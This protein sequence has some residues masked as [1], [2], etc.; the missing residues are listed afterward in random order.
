MV[1]TSPCAAPED[2]LCVAL[3]AGRLLAGLVLL[4]S[5]L[6]QSVGAEASSSGTPEPAADSVGA[7]PS[8]AAHFS[9][10]SEI[11]AENVAGLSLSFSFRTG[12]PRGHAAA[13]RV[14]GDTLLV[15]TP[16][17]HR[18]YALDLSKPDRPVRWTYAP[19]ADP[20][21][22]GLACCD[23]LNRGPVVADGRVYFNTLDG[24]TI[25]LDSGSGRVVWDVASASLAAGETLT[26][27]PLVAGGRVYIGN[28]GDDFGARGWIAA[29]EAETGREIWRRYSTGPDAEV[30]IGPAFKPFYPG[31][32]GPDL[33]V[34]TWPP[35][36]WEH[37]GGSVSGPLLHDPDLDLVIHG[38]GHPAPWNP[39]QRPGDNKWT[40]G[41]F[42]R[43]AASGAARWFDQLNPHDL[44]ALGA[45]AAS[46]P[47][48]RD[49]RGAR[50]R[51][52]IHAGAN[53]HVYVLDRL[54]GEILS[55]EPFTAVNATRG[56][57]LATGALRRDDA[58]AARTNV[59]ARDVCPA[60]TGATGSGAPAYSPRTEL[61][62]IPASRL[63]M[64]IEVRNANF[65]AGSA[66]TGANLRQK[67][68]A[69]GSR[70]ALVAWDVAA[71][72]AAWTISEDF[73]VA[74]GVL[75]TAGGLV[76][77]GTLDGDLKAADAAS[78][79]VLWRF[80]AS[81]G[82]IGEPTT[83]PGP[84]GRQYVAVMAGLGGAF[85]M[86]ARRGIDA[87]DATAAGGAANALR[88]LPKPADESGTLYVFRLP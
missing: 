45:T 47:V 2:G 23:V 73:P 7:A 87:R 77:Y 85:G 81:S 51:L 88:D 37:G 79:R 76:L 68:P 50:R 72:K 33:G 82:I 6:L 1:E 74:G 12:H 54:S 78:G 18:L 38:T 19:K 28:S 83:F 31:D 9:A 64:D 16:F 60:W 52:L 35:S 53:G 61:L 22:E 8:P 58:K 15:L 32:R 80:K 59:M 5:V 34:R 36:A 63:C 25:A 21:A 10:L 86:A 26:S 69:G 4:G 41:L 39:E 17:P 67:A 57:D 71:G 30:G 56:V 46:I 65:I 49:W 40:S 70:G 42:A 11:D 27:A 3:V 13:P 44:F 84:D 29:L 43:D 24:R 66:F 48:E 62:Y 75:A 20:M 14:S 55:A